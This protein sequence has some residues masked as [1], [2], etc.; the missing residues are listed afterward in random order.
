VTVLFRA[1]ASGDIL[2]GDDGL[3]FDDTRHLSRWVLQVDGA[4][5]VLLTASDGESVLVPAVSRGVPAPYAVFR[6]QAAD[7][8]GL[9]ESL[10]IVNHTPSALRVE[11]SYEVAADF[12]DQF[13]LRTDAVY[14][15]P[16]AVRSAD[17]VRFSYRR[18]WFVRET[19]LSSRPQWTID[20]PAGGEWTMDLQVG[21]SA[22]APRPASAVAASNAAAIDR[23]VS[24]AVPDDTGWAALD[25]SVAQGL[26]E[27]AA[28]RIPAPAVLSGSPQTAPD[29]TV[30]AAGAPWFLTLFGRDS[31]LASY[32]ALPYAPA[33]AR[34]VLRALAVFAGPDGKIIHEVRVGELAA[35]GQVPFARSYATVDATPLFLV[36]LSATRDAALAKELEQPA[37]AALRWIC[38]ALDRDGYLTYPTDEPGLRNQC[39]K[40]SGTSICFP[41]GTLADGPIAVCEA[42]GYA[43]DA[44]VRCAA[45]ARDAW[46]DAALAASL[47]SRASQLRSRFLRDFCVD[48]FVALALD[49]SGRP[50]PTM[51]S[52]PGHVLWSG[53]L[54]AERGT[55][56]GRRLLA[57]DLFNGW[58]IRT[59]AAGQPAYHPLSYHNGS[60]WPHDT[61]IAIAGL[62]RY[63]LRDEARAV[64]S[65]LL[66]A[67]SSVGGRLPELIAGYGRDERSSPVPYPHSCSPQAWA[68][69]APLLLRSALKGRSPY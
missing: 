37:R 30:V 25:R 49:G 55:A 56:V 12:A 26:R 63:G 42:Q 8:V 50:V 2:G 51:T 69:G 10:R 27:L 52:N 41:D 18:D 39:W 20:V 44:L 31:I 57:P 58:G 59:L 17:G 28:L 53:L 54:D 43:Y 61:A 48:D 15:K 13:E 29:L 11:V 16:G 36:L 64:A 62:A 65:G 46:G 32:F 33:L 45:L 35:F 5:P 23:F 40:D 7:E 60:V 4:R 47:G 24:A 66:A 34:D 3:F 9:A 19:V 1:S 6:V 68:A 14:E 67:A 21:R 38:A 22:A